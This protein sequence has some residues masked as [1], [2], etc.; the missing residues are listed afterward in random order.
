MTEQAIPSGAQRR[1]SFNAVKTALVKIANGG[2]SNSIIGGE[3]FSF[4]VCVY[5]NKD[6]QRKRSSHQLSTAW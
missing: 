4:D 1:S 6:I 2:C 3:R 5:T